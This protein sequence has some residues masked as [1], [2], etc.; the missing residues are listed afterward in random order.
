MDYGEHLKKAM[1][2]NRSQKPEDKTI[3]ALDTPSLDVARKLIKELKGVIS[4][5]KIG[6][7]LFTAH[8]WAA[9]DLVK[10]SGGRVFLDLKFHDIPN[11]VA[12]TVAVICEHEIEMFNVHALGGL[13]MMQ[14]VRKMIDERVETGKKKPVAL[15]VT[16]LTS[17]TES[18]LSQELGIHKSLQQEVCDLAKLVQKAGL[19]GV[20]SSPQ[21]TAALRKLFPNF[22]MVTPGVRPEGSSKGDQKRTFTPREALAAGADYLVIGRPITAA[23]NPRETTLSILKNLP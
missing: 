18:Q 8:G 20:V 23:A 1:K 2:N 11:T 9:V 10:K 16:I 12:K 3:V 21:E 14:G 15:G 7:E 19:E 17:H 6:F 13:E 22:L 4:F 5:Y